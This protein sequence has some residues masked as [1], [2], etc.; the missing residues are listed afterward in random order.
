MKDLGDF[1]LYKQEP[2]KSSL[3]TMRDMI[4]NYDKNITETR[5]YGMP[6]FCYK[7]KVFCYLWVD[8]KSMEPYFLMAN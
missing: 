1:C 2:D 8:K 4:L 7:G 3:L 5:K 6:C